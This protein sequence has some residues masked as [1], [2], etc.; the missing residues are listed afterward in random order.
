VEIQGIIEPSSKLPFSITIARSCQ[1]LFQ[2]YGAVEQAVYVT[3]EGD[4][5][6]FVDGQ[7]GEML[8]VNNGDSIE[9]FFAQQWRTP[10][11]VHPGTLHKKREKND[12]PALW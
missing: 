1:G 8:D 7:L 5:F 11:F 9:D 3:K 10:P 12:R 4:P 2:G 6:L